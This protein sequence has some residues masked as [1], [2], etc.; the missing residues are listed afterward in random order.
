MPRIRFGKKVVQ[1]FHCVYNDTEYTVRISR[2]SDMFQLARGS[3]K[4]AGFV[5]LRPC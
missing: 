4:Y 5:V 1:C 2:M 3:Y